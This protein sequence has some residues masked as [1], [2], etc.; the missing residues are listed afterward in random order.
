RR[1]RAGN[2]GRSPASHRASGAQPLARPLAAGLFH[3]LFAPA[4]RPEPAATGPAHERTAHLRLQN[5]ERESHAYALFAGTAGARPRGHG[6]RAAERGRAYPPGRDAR[7][8]ERQFYRGDHAFCLSAQRH[9]AEQRAGAGTRPD[10]ASAPRSLTISV[11]GRGSALSSP[12]RRLGSALDFPGHNANHSP[13]PTSPGIFL[14]QESAV[15]SGSLPALDSQLPSPES[16]SLLPA[17]L[18]HEF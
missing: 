8:A 15:R 9:A 5:R 17:S 11:W 1:R 18:L 4:Q 10:P 7:T 6:S 14:E 12:G 16:T 13:G 2:H 3:P